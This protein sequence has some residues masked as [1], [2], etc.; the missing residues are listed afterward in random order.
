M[1]I[2][3]LCTR[4][5]HRSP[6]P[7]RQELSKHNHTV[8]PNEGYY[9]TLQPGEHECAKREGA[10]YFAYSGGTSYQPSSNSG[11]VVIWPT[12]A[13]TVEVHSNLDMG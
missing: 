12:T 4:A 2:A 6:H 11:K 5:D 1:I 10:S 13:Y 9:N 7:L 8:T 3:Q